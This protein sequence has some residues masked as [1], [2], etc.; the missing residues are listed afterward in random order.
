MLPSLETARELC[1]KDE[2]ALVR[3]SRSPA[4]EKLTPS[5]LK[6][7]VSKARQLTEKW[8]DLSRSQARSQSR[9]SGSPDLESR[10]V[11]KRE[12]FQ[13][14]LQAFEAR[15]ASVAT[16]PA[17]A[18]AKPSRPNKTQLHREA[19]QGTRKTLNQTRKKMNAASSSTP[20]V[21][22]T[23]SKAAATTKAASPAA[24]KPKVKKS[25]VKAEAKK[26]TLVKKATARA[27]K[28]AAAPA[29][30]AKAATKVVAKPVKLVST[31]AKQTSVA[32]KAKA[33]RVAISNR[34]SNIAGHVSGKGKRAQ[35]RRDAKG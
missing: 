25:V 35:A 16:A 12:L 10:S 8:Q 21:A 3:A 6:S 14:A 24:V 27:A 30:P 9:Q 32:A 19:R 5:Q 11:A 22:A 31:K 13:G 28:K 2:L 7:H 33:N 15:L 4:L 20:A 17:G 1:T 34:T 23:A 29:V 18:V 26:K